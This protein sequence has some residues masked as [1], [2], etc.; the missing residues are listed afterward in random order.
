M[1]IQDKIEN[2]YSKKDMLV[3]QIA[4]LSAYLEELNFQ[5]AEQKKK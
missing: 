3:S 5:V 2:L 4:E 1:L